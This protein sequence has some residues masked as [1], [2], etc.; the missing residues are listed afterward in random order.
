MLCVGVYIPEW[1]IFIFVLSHFSFNSIRKISFYLESLLLTW[2][3]SFSSSIMASDSTTNTTTTNSTTLPSSSMSM[4]DECAN[5]PY[6]L[7]ST[8]SPSVILTSQPLIG[9][10][11]YMTSARSAFLALSARN[12]FGFVSGAIPVPDP[13]SPLHNTWSRCN[14]LVLSWLINS[15]NK[16]IGASVMSINTARDL[17]IDLEIGFLKK[18]LQGCVSRTLLRVV[19]DGQKSN[20]SS[21]FKLEPITI[22]HL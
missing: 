5:N 4:A 7:P 13:S 20:F 6:F 21:R 2:Y 12:K 3:Q 10:E 18:I 16:E 22:Y 1:E 19:I 11:N 14:T 9:Q 15:L 8:K 17:W